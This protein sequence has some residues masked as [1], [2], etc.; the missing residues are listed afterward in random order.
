LAE[1]AYSTCNA[2]PPDEAGQKAMAKWRSNKVKENPW[3][4]KYMSY[5]HELFRSLLHEKPT[6]ALKTAVDR[7][8]SKLGSSE[9]LT[10][11]SRGGSYC[12]DLA[13]DCDTKSK[14]SNNCLTCGP[15]PAKLQKF[16]VKNAKQ[17]KKDSGL[18]PELAAKLP[19]YLA[20]SGKDKGSDL[21]MVQGGAVAYDF[22]EFGIPP[23]GLSGPSHWM[24]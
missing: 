1:Y 6:G 19:V 3:H 11:H 14:P 9:F 8:T 15:T 21:Q 20:S 4:T 7:M 10:V 18:T 13:N 16:L 23:L 22:H 17:L 5:R 2:T 12:K 24:W